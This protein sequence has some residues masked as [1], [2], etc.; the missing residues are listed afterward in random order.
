MIVKLFLQS[1]LD[2]FQACDL[3]LEKSLSDQERPLL[4]IL[5]VSCEDLLE[6]YHVTF[7]SLLLL[8]GIAPKSTRLVTVASTLT[9]LRGLSS[10]AMP[11]AVGG[12]AS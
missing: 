8:V 10:S 6:S 9:L 1:C 2:V 5:F 3:H 12:V 11:S 4:K 7:K